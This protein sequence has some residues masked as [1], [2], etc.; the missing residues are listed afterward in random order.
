MRPRQFDMGDIGKMKRLV[1]LPSICLILAFVLVA[2]DGKPLATDQAKQESVATPPPTASLPT[3]TL[4]PI[5]RALAFA[6]AWS[7]GGSKL[8]FLDHLEGGIMAV[9]LAVE[10]WTAQ[11]V[12]SIP[13]PRREVDRPSSRYLNVSPDGTM[14]LVANGETGLWLG[15]L[16][17]GEITLVSGFT[18][19]DDPEPPPLGATSEEVAQWLY[20][21][22]ENPLGVGP[23][24]DVNSGL[25]LALKALILESLVAGQ[26]TIQVVDFL[27]Q[28]YGPTIFLA[29]CAGGDMFPQSVRD[30]CGAVRVLGVDWH[31]SSE[32]FIMA[33]GGQRDE[34]G[35]LW[36]YERDSGVVSK[37]AE[38]VSASR[39]PVFSPDGRRIAFFSQDGT[40]SIPTVYDTSTGAVAKLSLGRPLSPV[41][42]APLLWLDDETLVFSASDPGAESFESE[43]FANLFTVSLNGQ[44]RQLTASPAYEGVLAV[45][46]SQRRILF[47]AECPLNEYHLLTYTLDT[48]QIGSLSTAIGLSN[49]TSQAVISP[50]NHH[51]AFNMGEFL[52]IAPFVDSEPLGPESLTNCVPN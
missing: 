22:I 46:G 28:S 5:P 26:T 34:F 16:Q 41:S 52:W 7:P 32:R 13:S 33:L 18:T 25:G 3:L 19:R 8:Y 24:R 42:I 50:D 1:L 6:P 27:V 14:A 49:R 35:A 51:L 11:L 48:S 29:P 21:V 47:E 20:Q 31:P 38:S 10:P 40:E 2:C 9:D 15:N 45:D 37:V 12:L 36:I 39:E 44:H 43:G 17:T 30:R 23:L 4:S